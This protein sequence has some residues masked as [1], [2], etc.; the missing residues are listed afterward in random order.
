VSVDYRV[1][2]GRS[3][4]TGTPRGVVQAVRDMSAA[5]TRPVG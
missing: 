4:V 3:K 5:L 1:R 2:S